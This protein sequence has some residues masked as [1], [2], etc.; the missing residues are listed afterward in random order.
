MFSTDHLVLS[1]L[2]GDSSL[3]KIKPPILSSLYQFNITLDQDMRI[4]ENSFIDI[5]IAIDSVILLD[6]LS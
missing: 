6:L 3:G 5:G 4:Q 2:L 1:N